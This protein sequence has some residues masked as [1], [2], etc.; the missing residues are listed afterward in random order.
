M[1][2][3]DWKRLKSEKKT[4]LT[5]TTARSLQYVAQHT[6][7]LASGRFVWTH[8]CPLSETPIDSA[9]DHVAAARLITAEEGS[10]TQCASS[11]GVSSSQVWSM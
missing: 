8:E 6:A 9:C 5:W 4:L 10:D 11:S 1:K 2:L 3:K 7:Q